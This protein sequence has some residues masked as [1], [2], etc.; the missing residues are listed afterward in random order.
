LLILRPSR[1]GSVADLFLDHRLRQGE[2]AFGRFA[3][4][5][6]EALAEVARH[7]DVLHLVA[8]DRHLWR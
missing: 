6:V 2:V 7:L 5:V 3:V 4:E 8:P 1:P